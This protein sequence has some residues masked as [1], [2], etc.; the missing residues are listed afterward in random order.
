M[1]YKVK[2]LI[3][4][5][6]GCL[7]RS[8][9]ISAFSVYAVFLG[10]TFRILLIL[11]KNVI[12]VT[13]AAMISLTGSARNTANTLFSKNIGRIKMSG[14]SRMIFLRHARSRLSFA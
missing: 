11:V 7:C 2:K 5:N 6:G 14:I 8:F 9:R 10:L 3:F 13:A 4:G 1:K 12:V